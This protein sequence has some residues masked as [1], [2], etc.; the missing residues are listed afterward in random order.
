MADMGAVSDVCTR[1]SSSAD[2]VLGNRRSSAGSVQVE[3][4]RAARPEEKR[5]GYDGGWAEFLRSQAQGIL[6]M[7][8]FTADLLNRTKVYVFAVIE[9]GNR[10][11]RAWCP[12]GPGSFLVLPATRDPAN[13]P[14]DAGARA[15][16]VLHDR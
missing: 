10:R 15:K 13:G 16:F 11:S 14:G 9:H 7:D 4:H 2:S 3:P 1:R 5:S 6:A 12:R 8:F